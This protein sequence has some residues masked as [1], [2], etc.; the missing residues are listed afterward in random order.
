MR[1]KV[2]QDFANTLC[3][4]IVD[5][6]EGFDLATFAYYGTGEYRADILNGQCSHNDTIIPPLGACAVYKEW[7]SCQ[8]RKHRVPFEAVQSVTMVIRIEVNSIRT[9]TSYGHRFASAHFGTECRSEI[10]T[11]EKLYVGIAK[12]GK[13]WGFDWYY[14]RLYGPLPDVWPQQSLSSM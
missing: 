9:T 1:R 4:R 13:D 8:A 7:L 11:D 6:P 5:L 10:K 2:I 14:E 12:G 3:Q